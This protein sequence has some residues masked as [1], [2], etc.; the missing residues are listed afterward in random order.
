MVGDDSELSDQ[1]LR[2]HR[3]AAKA[4]LVYVNSFDK[5][6][7]RRRHGRG[8]TYLST[9]GKTITSS[10]TRK[11]IEAL[12]IPPA[13]EQVWICPRANGHI[14]AMGRDQ[15]GRRQYIY[16]ERWQAVSAAAKYD[17]LGLM[18]RLLPRIRRRVRKDLNGTRLS[19]R[20]VVA[21]AVRLVDKAAMRVGNAVYT[22]NHG[23]RGVTTLG[24]EHVDI[25]GLHVSLEFT[26]K[27]G[28]RREV[29]L[30]DP[31]LAKI[32]DRCE[33]IAGQFLFCYR[34][35]EGD[36]APIDSGDVNAYL[37][38]VTREPVTAKDFR[39]WAGSVNA[40]AYLADTPSPATTAARKRRVTRAVDVTAKALGNTRSVCRR[41]YIHPALLAAAE[42]GEL[43]EL[44]AKAESLRAE[45][46]AAELTVDE[47]R[48]AA[49]LP[50]L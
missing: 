39:T 27:S 45:I 3:R 8:Y 6:Y 28:R 41:S 16:H 4:N 9:R 49:L 10:R 31:K 42:T 38:R 21:A 14:Q 50:L 12:A 1:A 37:E 35:D 19:K 17:R 25:D 32:I 2:G 5:G 46:P 7:T 43:D 26:G 15:A 13:W 22:E 30:R 47:V 34:T 20:R 40:L 18:A 33:E 48:F 36:Y 29:G 23:T 24:P 44:L 11:R